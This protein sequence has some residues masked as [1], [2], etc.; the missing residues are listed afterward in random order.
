MN[1]VT[2]GSIGKGHTNTDM[3]TRHVTHVEW[4]VKKLRSQDPAFAP[5]PDPAV[6]KDMENGTIA[7]MPNTRMRCTITHEKR[8]AEE[9]RSHEA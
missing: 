9:T 7:G 3:G 1:R 8:D 5:D 2:A 6:R 4:S